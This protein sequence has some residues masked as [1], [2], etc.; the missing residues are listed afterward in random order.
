LGHENYL[1]VFHLT[2]LDHL[3]AYR[4]AISVVHRDLRCR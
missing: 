2:E 1:D 3:D 4:L